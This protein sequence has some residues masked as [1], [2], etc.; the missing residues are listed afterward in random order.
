[1]SRIINM[2]ELIK[3]NQFY[4]FCICSVAVLCSGCVSTS[5][6]DAAPRVSAQTAVNPTNNEELTEKTQPSEITTLASS[7]ANSN[8][9]GARKTGVF[10][11][12]DQMPTS[13]A[14]PL[15]DVEIDV[16]NAELDMLREIQKRKKKS[17]GHYNARLNELKKIAKKHGTDVQREIE[18]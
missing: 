9:S 10:P 14:T 8:L 2:S 16:V 13:A 3:K 15:S 17:K 18:N 1:M 5:L 7:E 11:K 12:F 6:E 4:I